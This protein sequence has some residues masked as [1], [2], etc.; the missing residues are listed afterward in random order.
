M[1]KLEPFPVSTPSFIFDVV[2]PCTLVG[3]WLLQHATSRG[4]GINGSNSLDNVV[5]WRIAYP[6]L[7]GEVQDK[8]INPLVNGLVL[9]QFGRLA[10]ISLLP[11]IRAFHCSRN[12]LIMGHDI[13]SG[14]RG[15]PTLS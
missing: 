1:W 9:S 2:Q 11:F 4:N 12:H 6:N 7:L 14:S 10:M 15:R 13:L 3:S 8:Q 5:Q